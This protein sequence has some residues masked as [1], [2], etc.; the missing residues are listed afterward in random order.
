MLIL[1]NGDRE[2]LTFCIVSTAYGDSEAVALRFPVWR[3]SWIFICTFDPVCTSLSFS[4]TH[5]TY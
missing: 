1:T 5:I 2:V 3:V 4:E